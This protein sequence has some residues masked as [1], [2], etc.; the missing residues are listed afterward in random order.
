MARWR[1]AQVD[2]LFQR[3]G[4]VIQTAINKRRAFGRLSRG[5]LRSTLRSKTTLRSR[6]LAASLAEC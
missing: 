4:R 3:I 2:K 1:I 6:G 5:R